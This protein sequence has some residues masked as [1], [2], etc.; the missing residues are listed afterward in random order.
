VRVRPGRHGPET[1]EGT[2]PSPEL[3]ADRSVLCL[4]GLMDPPMRSGRFE[5]VCP[6]IRLRHCAIVL[7]WATR[8]LWNRES[9]TRRS[10][11]GLSRYRAQPAG[12][13][14]ANRAV[15]WAR[16]RELQQ[17]PGR[18]GHRRLPSEG[19]VSGPSFLKITASD[20]PL[21]LTSLPQFSRC[22]V[23]LEVCRGNPLWSGR[24]SSPAWWSL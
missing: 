9:P 5:D 16:A 18:H 13:V 20:D 17:R 24:G 19:R 22:S 10:R 3:I 21:P 1:G 12:G 6:E 11:V 23:A 8:D 2:G 14:T 4:C 15:E 7:F